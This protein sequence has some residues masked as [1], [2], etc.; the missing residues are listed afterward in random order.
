MNPLVAPGKYDLTFNQEYLLT[1]FWH[2]DRWM[3]YVG[4]L[5][6]LLFG[7]VLFYL[8]VVI[9]KHLIKVG[10]RSVEYVENTYEIE[11]VVK[12]YLE[13]RSKLYKSN[14]NTD[15][16]QIYKDY[17]RLEQLII[18]LSKHEPYLYSNHKSLIKDYEEYK[19]EIRQRNKYNHQR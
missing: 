17:G 15:K 9:V 6:W 18:E 1:R 16:Y 3:A 8:F 12:N 14:S 7:S 13:V 10:K 2:M 5:W 11:K 19:E 4:I